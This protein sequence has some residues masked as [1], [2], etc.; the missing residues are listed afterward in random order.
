MLYTTSMRSSTEKILF[1]FVG[2]A[3]LLLGIVMIPY[4]GPGWLVVFAGLAILGKRFVWAKRLLAF[5]RAKY[6]NWHAWI[7]VQP[8]YIRALFWTLTAVTVIVTLWLLNVYGMLAAL[9]GIE[10]YWLTSPFMW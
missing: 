7:V 3:V 2:W 5:A 1:G 6:D 10:T 9:V 4:P 8:W